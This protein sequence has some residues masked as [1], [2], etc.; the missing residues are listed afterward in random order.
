MTVA[1]RLKQLLDSSQIPYK[2][3]VHPPAY[4]AEQVAEAAHV[5]GYD[6]AKVVIV[7]ADGKHVMIVLPANHRIELP[8]L[9]ALLGAKELRLAQEAEFANDF[10]DCEIGAMPP[11]GSLY[12]LPLIAS[13]ALRQDET[14]YFNG[15]SH[16]EIVQMKREDWERVAQ[17][18]WG[19]FSRI[20]V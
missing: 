4:T 10:P 15:G 13:E 1:I 9:Q 16:R 17:P 20:A 5:S 11:F 14:I 19:T 3:E 18:S 7:V 8:A 2:I 12:N 6:M